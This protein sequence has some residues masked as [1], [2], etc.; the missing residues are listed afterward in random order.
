[1]V[2]K[3]QNEPEL[4]GVMAHEIAHVAARHGTKQATR[5]E[6]ANIASLPIMLMGGWA[7]FATRQA[8]GFAIPMGFLQFSRGMERQADQLG[9]EYLYRTGYD[10]TSFLDFFERLQSL[11]KR[12]PGTIAKVFSTHPV[13]ADRIKRAQAEIQNEFEPQPQYVIDTSEFHDVQNRLKLLENRRPGEVHDDSKPT[14]RRRMPE[15][16]GDDERPTLKRRD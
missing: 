6:L 15:H 16:G 9:L 8:A 11:E 12:K 2:L 5:G 3:A 10:P 1:L 7:G 14:L 4:A 13:T